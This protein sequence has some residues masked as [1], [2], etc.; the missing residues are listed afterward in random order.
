MTRRLILTLEFILVTI[1]VAGWWLV[2]YLHSDG[3]P[4]ENAPRE[5]LVC[6][7]AVLVTYSAVLC[8]AMAGGERR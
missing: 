5:S 3:G 2:L 6:W 8:G 4:L 1:G 7:L